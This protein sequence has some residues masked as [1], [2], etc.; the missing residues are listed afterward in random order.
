VLVPS[1]SVGVLG[2]VW[3]G[4]ESLEGGN[5]GLGGV[6]AIVLLELLIRPQMRIEHEKEANDSN[7]SCTSAWFC[8]HNGVLE[9]PQ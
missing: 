5:I 9:A 4:G 1:G 8:R 2:C 7:Q 3:G 6:V